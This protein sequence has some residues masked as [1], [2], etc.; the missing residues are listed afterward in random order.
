[1]P[2]F[3]ATTAPFR[4]P[5][6]V[7]TTKSGVMSVSASAR[8]CPTWTAPY[9]A[10]PPS[11]YAIGRGRESTMLKRAMAHCLASRRAVHRS[12]RLTQ[13]NYS[14]RMK[15]RL[16]VVVAAAAVA[17]AGCTSPDRS[18]RS[19]RLPH[20]RKRT[21][22]W[23]STTNSSCRGSPAGQ[24]RMHRDDRTLTYD[25]PDGETITLDVLRVPAS[26]PN[27]RLGSLVLNPGG[28]GGSGVDYARA[29][30]WS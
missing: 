3:S 22:R 17:L 26:D 19:R 23:P 24:V 25:A 8:R 9:D 2:G 30:R 14:R 7:P 15:P 4:E 11:T 1:M 20:R 18:P 6:E 28:P 16:F 5:T 12:G 21:Q 27:K 29:A 10:P 13:D